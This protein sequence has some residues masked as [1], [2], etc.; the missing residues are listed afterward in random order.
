MS[1]TVLTATPFFSREIDAKPEIVDRRKGTIKCTVSDDS[2][3]LHSSILDP[4]GCEW[5]GFMRAG[6]PVMLNHDQNQQIGNCEHLSRE[7]IKGRRSI[8]ATIRLWD[9]DEFTRTEKERIMSGRRRAWSI[10][11]HPLDPPTRTTE[12]ERRARPDWSKADYV[13]RHWDL[14]EI[15][16]VSLN[17]NRYSVTSEVNRS[18]MSGPLEQFRG[19]AEGY[20]VRSD[21]FCYCW[22]YDR[23]SA[24]G[25]TYR[26]MRFLDVPVTREV[27]QLMCEKR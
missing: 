21:G 7:T 4:E 27:A 8:V 14:I 15:S 23:I 18:M 6:G 26:E 16:C 12:A 2:V 22:L 17:S 24:G 25:K 13:I 5:E 11:G 19:V 9:D 20:V 1:T 10:K 3:D